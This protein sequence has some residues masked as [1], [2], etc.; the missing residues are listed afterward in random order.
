MAVETLEH[1]TLR[2]ANVEATRV[3]YE[4][5]LGLKAG[6]RPDFDFPGYWIYCAGAPMIQLLE[7][8]DVAATGALD[9]IA[10]RCTDLERTRERFSNMGVDFREGT[11]PGG[12]LH[13]ILLTDPDGIRIELNFRSS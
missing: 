6:P 7:A 8:K 4:N 11:A 13:Q 1:C 2:C 12:R 3:F 5:V 10:F 9:H